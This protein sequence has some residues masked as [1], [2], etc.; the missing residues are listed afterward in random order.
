MSR[1]APVTTTDYLEGRWLPWPTPWEE[2]FD[3]AAPLW[4]EIGFGN[5]E[6]LLNL[7]TAY[8]DVNVLGVEI[9]RPS[10]RKAARKARNR[11]LSNVRVL[12]AT[13]QQVLWLLCRPQALDAVFINFPDPWPK[14]AHHHRRLINERFLHLLATRTEPGAQLEVATDHAEYAQ[15]IA[16]ALQAS[17][18]FEGD[19][20]TPYVTEDGQRIRT[21]Y[22]RIALEEGRI[23]HYFHWQRNDVAAINAFPISEEF[24]MPHV[25][26]AS[27]LSLQ[28]LQDRFEPATYTEHGLAVRFIGVFRSQEHEALLLDTYV[29]E[30]PLA[31]RIGITIRRRK[32][33]QY[34]LGLHEMGFPRPTEGVHS[35][36]DY[37]VQ[38]VRRMDPDL[39]I[40][41]S[42]LRA[43]DR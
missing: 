43:T 2:L 15:V 32:E 35:A 13:A 12:Y 34:V 19:T 4:M 23:C 41:Q 29:E 28:A 8:P 31:Q 7:A 38:H 30:E 16:A 18:Y 3:R 11:G 1:D 9:S 25:I 20:T 21:K 27:S 26:V 22:E 6:F 36:L 42:N 10:L 33:G 37:L 17:P 5:G 24:S 40:L 39:R 14:A